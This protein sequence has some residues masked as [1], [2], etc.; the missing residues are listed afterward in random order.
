MIPL[1][2]VC[3]VAPAS[4]AVNSDRENSAVTQELFDTT[5]YYRFTTQWQGDGKSMDIVNDGKNNNQP[6]LADTGNYSGQFWKISRQPCASAQP[7]PTPALA[8]RMYNNVALMADNRKY[9][10]AEGGGD[11]ELVAN[12]DSIGPWESF[13]VTHLGNDRLALQAS[14]GKYVCAENGGGG[15]VVANRDRVGEWET[16]LLVRV[17]GSRIALQTHNGHYL[18]AEGGGGRELV[19]NRL[20]IG[21]WESFYMF[22]W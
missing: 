6:I 11:R 17:S 16:F 14:N 5:C 2:L 13:K 18:S 20:R 15:A 7:S 9:V 3:L 10:A 19:A 8:A 1:L 12:R 4:R 21:P 22:P